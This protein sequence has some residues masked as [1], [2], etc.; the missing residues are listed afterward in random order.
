MGL[1]DEFS[2]FDISLLDNMKKIIQGEHNRIEEQK[3]IAVEIFNHSN[4]QCATELYEF[5][6]EQ[7][8]KS[9]LQ[10]GFTSMGT[11]L[12]IM[13]LYKQ[14]E[15]YI[16]T[17]VENK[18]PNESKKVKKAHCSIKSTLVGYVAIDELRLIN[19]SIKHQ[20]TV[21]ALLASS[22]SY[23]NLDQEFG[24]L[25]TVYERLKHNVTKYIQ[26]HENSF[27]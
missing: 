14:C 6:M 19:N 22:Y 5:S 21:S 24:D 13:G 3:E 17:I 2:L 11:E 18:Y 7:G 1:F 25:A 16:K 27:K 10:R 20:G 12:L 8:F 9:E 23:W 26:A 4:C 15:V